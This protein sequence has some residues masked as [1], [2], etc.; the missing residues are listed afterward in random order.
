MNFNTV[1]FRKYLR[2]TALIVHLLSYYSSTAYGLTRID[3]FKLPM[4]ESSKGLLQ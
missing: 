2:R 1:K 3:D 4:K